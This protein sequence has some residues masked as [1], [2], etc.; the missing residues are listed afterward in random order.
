MS[1]RGWLMWIPVALLPVVGKASCFAGKTPEY[2]GK[3]I[4]TPEPS[5]ESELPTGMGWKMGKPLNN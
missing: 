5:I 1:R 2:K 4:C 3:Y